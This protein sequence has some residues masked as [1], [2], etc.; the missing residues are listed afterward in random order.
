MIK[1]IYLFCEAKKR[2]EK[3]ISRRVAL[4]GLII[5][6]VDVGVPYLLL[7]DIESFFGCFFFWSFLTLLVLI[8][9]AWKVSNWGKK[10]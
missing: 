3:K 2:G 9:G 7:K 8:V 4:I 1:K 10:Q 6:I 5:G